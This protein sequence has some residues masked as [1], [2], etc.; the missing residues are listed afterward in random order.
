[1]Y[2]VTMAAAAPRLAYLAPLLDPDDVAKMLWAYG[3]AFGGSSGSSSSSRSGGMGMVRAVDS[4]IA[5]LSDPQ[6]QQPRQ[7]QQRQGHQHVAILVHTL[8]ARMPSCTAR[9]SVQSCAMAVWGL[10]MLGHRD[11]VSAGRWEPICGC[12]YTIG[13]HLSC[14]GGLI[15]VSR[16]RQHIK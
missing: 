3:K 10:A 1:M 14:E 6:R 2:A 12:E 13:A 16:F 15:G 11:E 7:P 9:M 8:A 5:A 4:N